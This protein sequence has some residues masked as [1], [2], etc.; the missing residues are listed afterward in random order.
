MPPQQ[1]HK[2]VI[3]ASVLSQSLS[4]QELGRVTG[5]RGYS[6][7]ATSKHGHDVYE[8]LRN[9]CCM[10][11]VQVP[12]SRFCDATKHRKNVYEGLDWLRQNGFIVVVQRNGV[13][14]IIVQPVPTPPEGT[15]PRQSNKGSAF[16]GA[17]VLLMTN[18][19]GF[20]CDEVIPDG[21]MPDLTSCFDLNTSTGLRRFEFY[22]ELRR[23]TEAVTWERMAHT[24]RKTVASD[25]AYLEE[26]GLVLDCRNHGVV[27]V[28]AP[29]PLDWAPEDEDL[30]IDHWV[31]TCREAAKRSLLRRST[32]QERLLAFYLDLRS[33]IKQETTVTALDRRAVA[34][35][36]NDRTFEQIRP[37][38]AYFMVNATS[39]LDEFLVGRNI[40]SFGLT[41]QTYLMNLAA[42]EQGHALVASAYKKNPDQAWEHLLKAPILQ[43]W[44]INPL[45]IYPDQLRARGRDAGQPT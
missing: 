16:Y 8:W 17:R 41:P 19:A 31:T 13:R 25:L 36:L 29:L 12:L 45:P 39:D 27:V 40:G 37:S 34:K 26:V 5:W 3:K 35:L 33:V 10:A 11:D 22:Q 21:E 23:S 6:S 2:N 20:T 7:S 43:K 15:D 32:G 30:I 28:T 24:T 14:T 18:A 4:R 42:I 1:I 9:Q 44:R 38:F